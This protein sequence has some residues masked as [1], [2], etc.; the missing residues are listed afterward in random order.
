MRRLAVFICLLLPALGIAQV[1]SIDW[2]N[3]DGGGGTST[4]AAYSV[5]GTIGQPDA[6][7]VTNGVYSVSGGYWSVLNVL[8]TPG[9]PL[10]RI[11]VTGTNAVA[12]SWPS[13]ATGFVL[14]QNSDPAT[15]NWTGVAQSPVDDGTNRVVSIQAPVGNRFFRLSHP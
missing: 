2:S 8:Q 1:Y 5:S 10:L 4:G 15:T 6:G 3:V 7:L 12:L 13:P 11:F 9:A 14:Q